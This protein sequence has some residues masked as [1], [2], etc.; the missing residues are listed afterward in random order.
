MQIMGQGGNYHKIQFR[1]EDAIDSLY[2]AIS[3]SDGYDDTA[4]MLEAVIEL[5]NVQALAIEGVRENE[6]DLMMSEN[7]QLMEENQGLRDELILLDNELGVLRA[8][9]NT[10]SQLEDFV[11]DLSPAPIEEYPEVGWMGPGYVTP[12]EEEERELSY[13]GDTRMTML[14]RKEENEKNEEENQFWPKWLSFEK[15][16]RVRD[17]VSELE[18]VIVGWKESTDG[19]NIIYS[20]E[21]GAGF[22]IEGIGQEFVLLEKGMDIEAKTV[23]VDEEVPEAGEFFD[24]PYFDVFD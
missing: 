2:D 16:D 22:P 1:A 11:N 20:M 10:V 23:A 14:A 21:A 3:L 9:D 24:D 5:K 6:Y 7:T 18:G 8:K 13:G 12:F 15:G 4:S 19:F 17:T